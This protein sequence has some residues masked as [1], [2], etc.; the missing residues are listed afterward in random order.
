MP[1]TKPCYAPAGHMGKRQTEE[2]GF[3]AQEKLIGTPWDGVL[4]SKSEVAAT[5]RR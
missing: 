5:G 2:V 3:Q 1:D 4:A